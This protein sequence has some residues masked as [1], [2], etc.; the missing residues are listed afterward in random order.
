M[1]LHPADDYPFHQHPAPFNMPVTSDA[2]YNDGYWFAFYSAD[3]YFVSVLRLHPNVNAIDGAACVAHDGRQHC[4]RFSRALRPRYGDLDVGAL[5]LEILEPMQRLRLTLGD[6]PAGIRFDVELEAQAPPFVEERYQNFKYGAIIADTI[7]YTQVCRA[8]GTAALGDEELE[9]ADWYALRDHSWGVRASMG[10]PIKIGGTERPPEEL[11]HRALRLWVPFQCGDHAGF[12][13]SHE[14]PSGETL[15]FEGRLDFADGR[16]VE[17]AAVE[18]AL[19]YVPGTAWPSGGSFDLIDTDGVRRHYELRASGTPADVH[20]LGYYRGWLDGG[21]AG[22][23]RGPEHSEHNVYDMVPGNGKPGPEHVAEKR[24]LGPTEYPMHL[25]GSEGEG[26]AQVE[27][28]IYGRYDPYSF[29]PG[30]V[31]AAAAT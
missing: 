22:M 11:D 29:G 27:H 5:K 18:H 25:T 9:V 20:G 24:R 28:H 8:S 16:S 21:S 13:H 17:L 30:G 3:W 15:D 10:P 4:V 19:E 12:F 26:M 23:Y 31:P 2:K 7:R 1:R 6:N 14:D